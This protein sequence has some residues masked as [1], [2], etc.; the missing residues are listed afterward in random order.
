MTQTTAPAARR[1]APG[2]EL[3]ENLQNNLREPDALV[4]RRRK[5]A[6]LFDELPIPSAENSEE[7]RRTDVTD[8][9]FDQLNFSTGSYEDVPPEDLPEVLERIDIASEDRAGLYLDHNLDRSFAD[10]DPELEEQGVVLCTMAEAAREYPDLVEEHFMTDGLEPDINKFSALHAAYHAG[11]AFLYVPRDL[12]IDR[13]FELHTFVDEDGLSLNDHLLVVVGPN[14]RVNIVETHMSDGDLEERAVATSAVE[15]VAKEGARVDY[16]HIQRLDRNYYDLSMR[17]GVCEGNDSRINWITGTLGSG[18]AKT[19][20]LTK[21]VG[22]GSETYLYGVMMANE[23]QHLDSDISTTHIGPHTTDEMLARGVVLDRARGV[24]RGV[25][26]MR[27]GCR[28]AKG[29]LHERCLMVGEDAK[30]DAVPEMEITENDV[31]AAHSASVG[32]LDE[33]QLLYMQSRGISREQARRL[34]ILGFFEPLLKDLPVERIKRDLETMIH[35]KLDHSY[36]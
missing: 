8:L 24:F 31:K 20:A 1:L 6:E 15:I 13:A 19:S 21:L 5:G 33:D 18:K 11:G 22:E 16:S 32:E 7:W 27:G 25:I 17:R 34:I 12:E 29:S 3:L 10:L 35:D 2:P 23:D 30:A 9:E 14:S 28:K 36:G 4:N 26:D